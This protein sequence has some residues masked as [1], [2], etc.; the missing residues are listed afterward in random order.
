MAGLFEYLLQR[1]TG[2]R[3]SNIEL[4]NESGEVDERL[5]KVGEAIGEAARTVKSYGE[6]E[7]SSLERL[8]AAGRAGMERKAAER[9][10]KFDEENRRA[11]G[12]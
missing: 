11:L 10:K 6:G 8:Q 2:K 3:R 7:G 1:A 5:P 9:K 12:R 4:E